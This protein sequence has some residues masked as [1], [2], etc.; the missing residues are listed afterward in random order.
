MM[1][2]RGG[3]KGRDRNGRSERSDEAGARRQGEQERLRGVGAGRGPA[4]MRPFV[5][6]AG[7]GVRGGERA[8]RA[9]EGKG[10]AC[11]CD[12]AGGS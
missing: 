3:R 5:R 11:R 10:G 2:K 7:R 8:A 12:G 6:A 4:R 1:G 9:G